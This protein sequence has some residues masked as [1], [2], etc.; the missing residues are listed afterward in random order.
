MKTGKILC[1]VMMSVVRK[2]R[3][4]FKRLKRVRE[5][6]WNKETLSRGCQK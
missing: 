2:E 5:T 3:W 1:K 4:G 6:P